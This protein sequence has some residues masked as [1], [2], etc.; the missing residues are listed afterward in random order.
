MRG[1]IIYG[2]SSVPKHTWIL[3][4][5]AYIQLFYEIDVFDDPYI[6]LTLLID[7]EGAS[8]VSMFTSVLWV[9]WNDN[10]HVSIIISI[11]TKLLNINVY[12][13]LIL[14]GYSGLFNWRRAT[15]TIS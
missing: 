14:V 13:F 12:R 15:S 10:V 4:K 11:E 9:T 6:R 2:I 1:A 7:D 3:H 8:P 5:S